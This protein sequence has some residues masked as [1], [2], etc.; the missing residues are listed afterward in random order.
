MVCVSNGWEE[1]H[2]FINS[3]D[4]KRLR[5]NILE[6]LSNLFSMED[7]KN[8]FTDSLTKATTTQKAILPQFYK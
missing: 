3:I 5:P 7:D 8:P 4:E 1:C 6:P 2:S